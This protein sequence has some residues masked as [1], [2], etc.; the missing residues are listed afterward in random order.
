ME[1][2]LKRKLPM[3][4]G[5]IFLAGVCG[6]NRWREQEVIPLLNANDI[7]S[8]NPQ[9]DNWTPEFA[10]QEAKELEASD[11]ILVYIDGSTRCLNSG[12]ELIEQAMNGKRIFAFIQNV[13]DGTVIADQTVTGRELK[14][15]NNYRGWLVKFADRHSNVVICE[16]LDVAARR[17]MA[18]SKQ[19]A[20]A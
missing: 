6:G 7:P 5:K 10:V 2:V 19:K 8:F 20:A 3:S 9:V 11:V 17:A 4:Y 12:A 13:A 16:S 18:A 15:L 1:L 14:D